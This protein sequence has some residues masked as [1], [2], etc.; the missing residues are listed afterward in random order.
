VRF[1][2]LR[3]T[4]ASLLIQQGESLTYIRD[5]LGHSSIQMTVDIYGHL[6]PGG[7]IQAVDKLDDNPSEGLSESGSKVVADDPQGKPKYV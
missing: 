2:D 1:H 4:F 3:H 5:Q 7:N 6:V